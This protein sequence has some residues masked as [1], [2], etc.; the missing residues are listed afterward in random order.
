MI[1]FWG[2]EQLRHSIFNCWQHNYLHKLSFSFVYVCVCVFRNEQPYAVS[3]S[4]FCDRVIRERIIDNQ[5]ILKM[6]QLRKKFIDIV[7]KTE[8][9]DASDYR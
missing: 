5:E 3:Y 9:A 8:D 2:Q 6:N 7:K 4:V 1:L